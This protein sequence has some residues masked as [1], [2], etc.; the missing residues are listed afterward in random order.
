[1]VPK[2]P[3]EAP[4]RAKGLLPN[5][6][7]MSSAGR[8]SQSMAFLKTPG[9]PLLYSGVAEQ[10]ALRGND[11]LLSGYTWQGSLAR[12]HV[13][14]I[15]GT[16]CSVLRSRVRIRGQKRAGRPKQRRIE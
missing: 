16:P 14:I 7:L 15:K 9:M 13:R 12:L 10:H 11:G 8:E 3:G 6:R 5:T 2:P 4:I 1:M